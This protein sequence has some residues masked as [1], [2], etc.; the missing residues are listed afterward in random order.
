MK[1]RITFAIIKLGV[2]LLLLFCISV[3]GYSGVKVS[4]PDSLDFAGKN[5][6]TSS[7]QI[8]SDG[9][10]N[11]YVTWHDKRDGAH[12]IYF[13]SSGDYGETWLQVDKRLDE[14]D[15][16]GA[17]NSLN[18]QIS[19][20]GSGKVYVT[21]MKKTFVG[22]GF[23]NI[24]FNYSNDGGQ[25]WEGVKKLGFDDSDY[26]THTIS[27]ISSDEK[28]HVYVTWS[29]FRNGQLNIYFNYSKDHGQNWHYGKDWQANHKS[30]GEGY[31]PRICNDEN[32]NVYVTWHDKTNRIYFNYSE[33]YGQNWHYGKDWQAKDKSFD[34]GNDPQISCDE[35][36]N[37][38]VTWD[39]MRI[40]KNYNLNYEISNIYFKHSENKGKDW[41]N[42]E[43]LDS[44]YPDSGS[45]YSP[46]ISSDENGNVYVTWH[47]LTVG[48]PIGYQQ[49]RVYFNYS[50]DHGQ[51]WQEKAIRLDKRNLGNSYYPRISSDEKG[52]VYV[53]WVD[54]R[55]GRR[56]IY[57]NY[58]KDHE[59]KWQ[60]KD[61]RLDTHLSNTKGDSGE[62]GS[63]NVSNDGAGHMYVVWND[64]QKGPGV[65][66]VYF[67]TAWIPYEVIVDN[68]DPDTSSTGLWRISN[69][70]NSYGGDLKYN[71]GNHSSQ[72]KFTYTYKAMITGNYG[73]SM[74]WTHNAKLNNLCKDTEVEIYDGATW[75]YTIR[76][77]QGV[78]ADQWNQLGRNTYEFSSGTARVVIQ[79]Q[80]GCQ[81]IA[82]AVKF[83]PPPIY[84]CSDGIDNDENGL[85]D[86]P[87]DFYGCEKETDDS[88][89]SFSIFNLMKWIMNRL[90]PIP[91]RWEGGVIEEKKN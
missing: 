25:T 31:Y 53:T 40:D 76:V 71:D 62:Y 9:S 60:E 86:Y 34:G 23:S 37:V 46:Q 20:N 22:K 4:K 32:G 44:N 47:D 75:R 87:A 61:I 36:E 59:Q 82:D 81:V 51:K 18:P 67:N 77:D 80:A 58:S 56:D 8:S 54:D 88:E 69:D 65:N 84:E 2:V 73:V 85:I 91:I 10:G 7:P 38:Y 79:S 70:G 28:G 68:G 17:I 42:E 74:W 48:Y 39:D 55:N 64:A 30:L 83:V 24:F 33:D 50:K 35:N 15:P 66:G 27:Q 43:K 19:S 41:G 11:V 12:G 6:S 78:N 16:S 26:D 1:R 90:R 52:N 49:Q 21:W 45:S 57:F 3:N 13:N 14:G 63:L 5:H 89:Y 29:E 72:L